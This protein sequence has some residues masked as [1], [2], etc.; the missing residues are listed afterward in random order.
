MREL[1][2][3]VLLFHH[4]QPGLTP[5][6]RLAMFP[7]T[8]VDPS[9]RQANPRRLQRGVLSERA[10]PLLQPLEGGIVL[11]LAL[12]EHG[13]LAAQARQALRRLGDSDQKAPRPLVVGQRRIV[14]GQQGPH[15][16]QPFLDGQPLLMLAAHPFQQLLHPLVVANGLPSRV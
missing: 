3:T 4:P 2:T 15:V 1:C 5:L 16:A 8:R 7:L 13:R 10:Q 12:V 9:A 6:Q 14:L 11:P